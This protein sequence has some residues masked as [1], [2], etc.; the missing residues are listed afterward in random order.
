MHTNT[1]S[2]A[3]WTLLSEMSQYTASLLDLKFILDSWRKC[4]SQVS[5][6]MGSPLIQMFTVIG[7]IARTLGKVALEDIRGERE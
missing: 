3:A 5:M 6:A 2:Q 1:C 4:R 7:N